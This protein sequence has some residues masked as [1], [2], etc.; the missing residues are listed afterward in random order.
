MIGVP[1]STQRSPAGSASPFGCYPEAITFPTTKPTLEMAVFVYHTS[2]I[3]HIVKRRNMTYYRQKASLMSAKQSFQVRLNKRLEELKK[4]SADFSRDLNIT[5]STIAKY[6]AG[7]ATPTL[8]TLVRMS[9]VLGCSTD[10]LLGIVDE[11]GQV[12]SGKDNLNPVERD[13]LNL[14]HPRSMDEQ[15]RLLSIL[16]LAVK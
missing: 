2:I 14:I 13:I 6:R 4:S 15:R 1:A 8:D 5:S 3:R 7:T 16:R 10:Y 9:I 12:E 11:A